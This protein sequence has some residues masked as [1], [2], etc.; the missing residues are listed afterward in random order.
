MDA[1]VPTPSSDRCGAQ[2]SC[3]DRWTS[4]ACECA[5]ADGGAV[6]A[7][8]CGESLQPVAL[9][10]GA[11]LA[12]RVAETHRRVQLL[13]QVYRGTTR[14]LG[15][16]ARPAQAAT[17]AVKTL[18]LAFRTARR[19]G[20]LLY[21]ASNKDFTAIQVGLAESRSCRAVR[22]IF[23]SNPLTALLS[24]CAATRWRAGLHVAGR[25]GGLPGQYD[26]VRL[27]AAVGRPLA[28][29]RA[30]VPGPRPTPAAGR[31]ARWRRAGRQRRARLPGPLPHDAV[32]RRRRPRHL[33]RPGL[34]SR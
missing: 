9:A 10:E 27:G 19:D 16:A 3:V 6:L 29:R 14:W 8:D 25:S 24:L 30:R 22:P 4:A 17:T 11:F 2:G 23:S 12:F 34:S 33:P 32:C 7:P 20:L 15:K 1:P 28:P 21:A 31:P 13:D 26:G 18:S 5:A